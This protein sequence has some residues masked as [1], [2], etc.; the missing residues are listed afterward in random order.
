MASILGRVPSLFS[1]KRSAKHL[2]KSCKRKTKL[3]KGALILARSTRR[4][5]PM[6]TYTELDR[7]ISKAIYAGNKGA[8]D[9]LKLYKKTKN[10]QLSHWQVCK[11]QL[12]YMEF[13]SFGYN[14]G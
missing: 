9:L 14:R 1:F 6:P 3:R 4:P 10:K 13:T 7:M 2:N 5:S 11:E 12:E 8:L